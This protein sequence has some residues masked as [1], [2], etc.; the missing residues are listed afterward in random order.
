MNIVERNFELKKFF[1]GCMTILD[2][3]GKDYNPDGKAFSE[4]INEATSLGLS[5]EQYMS[6]LMSKHWGAIKTFCSTKQL[7]SEPITERCKDLANYCA[8]L[9]VM[10]AELN[11]QNQ[12]STNSFIFGLGKNPNEKEEIYK[13]YIETFKKDGNSGKYVEV[14]DSA[15]EPTVGRIVYTDSDGRWYINFSF[16]FNTSKTPCNGFF[17][18]EQCKIIS[19]VNIKFPE[20]VTQELKQK[21]NCCGSGDCAKESL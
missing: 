3:K 15:F 10:I 14:F 17:Y 4:I 18:P 2:K 9:A 5:P 21:D 16:D 20:G 19:K 12:C 11:N 1:D 6:V 13:Q 8:L 7:A